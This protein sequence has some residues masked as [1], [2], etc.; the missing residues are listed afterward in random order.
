MDNAGG[1]VEFPFVADYYDAA[2]ANSTRQDISFFVDMAKEVGGPVLEV[3]CG[4][5]RVLIPTAKA[6]IE[7]TGLDLSE[8][9]LDKCREKLDDESEETRNRTKLV[10]ADMRDFD[11]GREFTLIT[12]PFRPFQHLTTVDDQ[13]ACLNS[14]HRH[15]SDYGL[16]VLDIFNPSLEYITDKNRRDEFGKEPEVKLDDGRKFYRMSR[17]PE[18]DCANQVLSCE[19]IHYVT[20]PD[21]REERLV[22]SFPMRYTFRWEAE[23]ML[24]RCGFE[25]VSLYADFDKSEYG[26]KYPGEL[27]FVCKKMDRF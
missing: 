2:Y 23:H 1:H 4:T 3:G 8:W 24:A 10:Q 26:S 5:G 12:T 7:I 20:H 25:V 27:I 22:H 14:I 17:V 18:V 16:F 9:M 21:G 11:L 15:L 6:G 19:L 13:F